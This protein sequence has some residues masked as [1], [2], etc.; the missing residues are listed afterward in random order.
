MNTRTWIIGVGAALLSQ[1]A[2][3]QTLTAAWAAPTANTDGTAITGPITYNLYSGARGKEVQTQSA[4]TATT[5]AVPTTPGTQ[6]CVRVTAIV[7]AQESAQSAE[8][9]GTRNFS[10]PAAPGSLTLR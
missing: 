2:L 3:A 7:N 4:L 1:A 10:T 8:A 6:L 9:C 5:T